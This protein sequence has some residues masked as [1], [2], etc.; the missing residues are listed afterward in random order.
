L[1]ILA[2]QSLNI[3]QKGAK[4]G[5]LTDQNPQ[6]GLKMG[7]EGSDGVLEYWSGDLK[8]EL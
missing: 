5:E 1:N 7:G 2:S 3:P 8:K 6:I 4:M